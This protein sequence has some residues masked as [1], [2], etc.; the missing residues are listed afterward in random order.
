[1][2]GDISERLVYR[3]LMYA[4]ADIAGY[5]PVSGDLAY[6]E[7]LIMMQVNLSICFNFLNIIFGQY[8]H[9]LLS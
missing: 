5:K 2:V 6:P 7:K 9:N 4:Q 1:M 8:Y 3:A